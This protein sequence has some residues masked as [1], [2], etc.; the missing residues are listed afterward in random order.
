MFLHKNKK[1]IEYKK[2]RLASKR[3]DNSRMLKK[4]YDFLFV[5]LVFFFFSVLAYS[6]FF[7]PFLAVSVVEIRGLKSLSPETVSVSAASVY[8][9]KYLGI[10]P[11]ENLLVFPSKKV[12]RRMIED[13]KRIRQLH[14]SREFPNRIIIEIEERESLLVWCSFS[15]ECFMVDEEG[16]A[17]SR[18]SLDSEEVLENNLVKI[19]SGE[20]GRSISEGEKI[21]DR[22]R[23]SFLREARKGIFSKCGLETK[24]EIY[25]KSRMAEEIKL[26]SLEE[27]DI[28]LSTNFSIEKSAETLKLFLGKEMADQEK[29]KRLEYVDL[30]IENRTYYKFKNEEVVEGDG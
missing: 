5:L 3:E 13:F 20:D 23:T 9:G 16:Y 28:L 6:L 7:A 10:F 29:R 30:R 26:G 2:A 14:V 12:K 1:E 8:E 19:I 4:A 25:V 17:Y 21:L 22:E 18:V 11:K 15:G 27:W 24:N